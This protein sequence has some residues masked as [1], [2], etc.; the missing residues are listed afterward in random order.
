MLYVNS[1]ISQENETTDQ[2]GTL[3][4]CAEIL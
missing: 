3:I 4:L 1:H 2:D